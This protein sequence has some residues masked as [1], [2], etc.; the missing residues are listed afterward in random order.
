MAA[1]LSLAALVS[2]EIRKLVRS[3]ARDGWEHQ[4][5]GNDHVLLIKGK[6]SLTCAA[7]PSDARAIRNIRA[8]IRRKERDHG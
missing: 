1:A 6:L 5:R 3:L 2:P 7:T 8:E 4:Y